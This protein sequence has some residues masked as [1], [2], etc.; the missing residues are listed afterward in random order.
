MDEIRTF[1][2][3]YLSEFRIFQDQEQLKEVVDIFLKGFFPINN[4]T[5]EINFDQFYEILKQNPDVFKSLYLITIPD[6]GEED[7]KNFIWYQRWCT[8]VK[9]NANRIGFL[10]LYI[11]SIISLIIYRVFTLKNETIWYMIARVSGIL[12]NFNFAVAISLML[13][14]T[15]TIIRRIYYLRLLI[16]VDDH[17]DA[18]RLVGTMLSISALTHTIG[19]TV[20]FV[21]HTDSKYL[22]LLLFN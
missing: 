16:P 20:Q 18:H 4:D 19:H 7:E 5:Q 3:K 11:L 1:Y 21:T 17:I 2:Q 6:Q 15:M 8:Y 9:N 13:K 10:I 12:I 14:Q 22:F